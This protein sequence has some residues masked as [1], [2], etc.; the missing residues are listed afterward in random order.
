MDV[1]LVSRESISGLEIL[2]ADVAFMD[3]PIEM[4][5][6]MKPKL[7]F[8]LGNLP[9]HFALPQHVIGGVPALH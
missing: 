1:L 6:D 7:V 4:G 2:T 5:L 8:P 3:K 9:A